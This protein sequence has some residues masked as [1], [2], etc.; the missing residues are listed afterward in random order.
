MPSY[1]D[2]VRKGWSETIDDVK[3]YQILYHKLKK[4]PPI[5]VNGVEFFFKSQVAF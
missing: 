4:H 3:S 2:V 5:C 1:D